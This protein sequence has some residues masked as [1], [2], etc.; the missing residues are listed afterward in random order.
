MNTGNSQ[1]EH[2]GCLGQL[3]THTIHEWLE[4]VDDG[5]ARGQ[6]DSYQLLSPYQGGFCALVFSLEKD[7][8]MVDN[9]KKQLLFQILMMEKLLKEDLLLFL[10]AI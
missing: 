1:N 8:S 6:W 2:T 3:L 4:S 9:S 7:W 5:W 10:I